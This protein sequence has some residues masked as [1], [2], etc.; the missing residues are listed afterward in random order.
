MN[1]NF[2]ELF[3]KSLALLKNSS[4][5]KILGAIFTQ[6]LLSLISFV[7]SLFLTRY[8]DKAEYGIYVVLFSIMGIAG[9]FQ[10]AFA[11]SPVTVLFGKK[12]E[13]E[14]KDL[15]SGMGIIQII[16]IAILSVVSILPVL[17]YSAVGSNYDF[18]LK[19]IVF[20]LATAMF[21]S[22]EYLR[23]VNYISLQVK[24]VI[25]MD[26]IYSAVVM[27]IILMFLWINMIN[28]TTAIFAL[29]VGYIFSTIIGYVS[30]DFKF[31]FSIESI[32][33]SLAETF[34]YSKWAILGVIAGTLQNRGYIYIVSSMLSLN[35]TADIAA[36]RLLMMPVGLIE[37]SSI[38][39]VVS[40]GADILARSTLKK[41]KKFILLMTIFLI[42]VCLSYSL[43]LFVFYRPVVSL[44]GEKYQNI[45]FMVVLWSI[46]FVFNTVRFPI[47][48]SL[49]LF[50]EFRIVTINDVICGI[51]TLLCCFVMTKYYG[52]VGALLSQ[53]SGEIL[54]MTL[55]LFQY[56]IV[57]KKYEKSEINSTKISMT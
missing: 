9:N 46:F 18:F 10:N 40:K 3:S 37:T 53:I 7:I 57:L 41:F 27:I 5:K 16:A 23:T 26:V 8:S 31:R 2:N 17:I 30:F 49:I 39:I 35:D 15:I 45:L 22:K 32:K 54:L 34:V 33:K 50:K 21:L 52:K 44:L 6:G 48:N 36:A 12:T 43:F 47:K 19:Y 56:F 24:K 42:S 4:V 25:R 20:I 1:L 11:N 13:K 29:F 28:C 38:K 51:L 14:K 55:S